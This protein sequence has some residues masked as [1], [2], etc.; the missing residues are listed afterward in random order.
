MTKRPDYILGDIEYVLPSDGLPVSLWQ[1][2][3]RNYATWQSYFDGTALDKRSPSVADKPAS[4]ALLYPLKINLPKISCLTH[5]NAFVGDCNL[6]TVID[7]NAVPIARPSQK[8]TA[9]SQQ[10]AAFCDWLWNRVWGQSLAD[11]KVLA[12]A[13]DMAVYGGQVWKLQY[14]T[15]R[16]PPVLMRQVPVEYFFPIW[17]D[18]DYHELAAAILAYEIN[19]A[20]AR[21][22]YGVKLPQHGDSDN[23]LYVEYWTRER[24]VSYVGEEVRAFED[25][26]PMD[27][28]NPFVDG[29][30]GQ[31]LIPFEYIP[32]RRASEFYGLSLIDDLVGL[33]K[34][35]NLR[36]AD[37]GDAISDASHAIRWIRNY[38]KSG[39]GLEIDRNGFLNLGMGL[40]SM[41][42][43]E[44]GVLEQPGLPS[45]SMEFMDFM[46]RLLRGAAFTPPVAFG[47][48]EGSQR[49]AL[50]IA[51]R[52]WPL[53]QDT[54]AARIHF[55]AGMVSLFRKIL[56]ILD[57]APVRNN[58]YLSGERIPE[59]LGGARDILNDVR[60]WVKFAP[61][62]PRD[63]QEMVAE[64][65]N[66]Y[67]AGLITR[68][69]AVRLLGWAEDPLAEVE[70]LEAEERQHQEQQ[71]AQTDPGK[72]RG[73][74]NGR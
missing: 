17:D 33:T 66:L 32:R 39:R 27:F 15:R 67:G 50:T 52:M 73:D 53:I 48:D 9:L 20:M 26:T 23:V 30:T 60:M 62:Q 18:T 25:G 1:E 38:A 55:N 16:S 59:S 56:F 37:F 12:G 29:F 2:Q 31:G 36:A 4:E 44:V 24:V 54:N 61:V 69:R 35:I 41:G 34:E 46:L 7:F 40:A 22:K 3:A 51:S 57:S 65:I 42:A 70:Q 28:P 21:A 68:E 5:A 14:T 10:R 45:G 72:Q 43:P 6:P 63:R 19:V 74:K 47:E 11:T 8:I 13:L 64:I 58:A 71:A 49:S